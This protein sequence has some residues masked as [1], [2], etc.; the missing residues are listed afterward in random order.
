MVKGGRAEAPLRLQ[1][2]R[3]QQPAHKNERR[4]EEDATADIGLASAFMD[5]MGCLYDSRTAQLM[6]D[7][8]RV[9]NHA[10]ACM[11]SSGRLICAQSVCFLVKTV[12]LIFLGTKPY[13]ARGAGHYNPP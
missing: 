9:K 2:G 8:C 4:G 11:S 1:R 12:Q 10:A 5:M 7:D 13:M 6:P 3:Q